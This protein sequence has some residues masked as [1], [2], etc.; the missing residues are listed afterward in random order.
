ML[1][2]DPVEATLG[3]VGPASDSP[4]TV[5]FGKRDEKSQKPLD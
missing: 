5:A 2:V 3:V 4:A 1:P